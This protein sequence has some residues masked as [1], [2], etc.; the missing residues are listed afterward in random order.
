MDVQDITIIGGRFF[1]SNLSIPSGTG[2]N[3]GKKMP[4]TQDKK[5]IVT[6]CILFTDVFPEID[7]QLPFLVKCWN[8]LG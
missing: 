7:R 6:F 3:L 8:A 5:I 2:V 4:I 1:H